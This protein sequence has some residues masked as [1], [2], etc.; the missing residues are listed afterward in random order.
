M[1]ESSLLE[2]LG[3]V[4]RAGHRYARPDIREASGALPVPASR[5]AAGGGMAFDARGDRLRLRSRVRRPA[6]TAA[7]E[8]PDDSAIVQIARRFRT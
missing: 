6:V 3:L 7:Q 1:D 2:Y 5:M 8:K 4:V